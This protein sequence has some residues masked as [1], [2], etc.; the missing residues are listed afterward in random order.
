MELYLVRHTRVAVERGIFYGHT[1][2]DLAETSAE[3]FARLRRKLP[4]T[5]F[6]VFTSPSLRCRTIAE[7]LN[8]SSLLTDPRLMELNFGDWEMKRPEEI[9]AEPFQ[10]WFD[11]FVE[12]PSPNG[13]TFRQLYDRCVAWFED[14]CKENYPQNVVVTHGGVIR[15]LLSHILAFPLKN[16]FTLYI[17]FGSVTKIRVG[18]KKIEV[19]Y[20]NR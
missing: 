16:A 15:A 14:V 8:G 18:S 10:H 20:V 2:V 12:V 11:N 4:K 13:E 9:P 5:E 3:D 7:K 1:D 17:A 19:L 6:N